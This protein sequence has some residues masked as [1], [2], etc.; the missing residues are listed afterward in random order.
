LD[1][2]E[3]LAERDGLVDVVLRA[4]SKLLVLLERFVAR[5]G[6][7]DDERHILEVRVLLELV[8]NGEP[9]HPR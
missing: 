5:F 2:Q 9:V 6:R 1:V 7:H 4:R 8:A 3:E